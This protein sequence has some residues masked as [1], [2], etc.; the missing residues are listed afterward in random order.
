MLLARAND[1]TN[2]ASENAPNEYRGMNLTLGSSSSTRLSGI[3]NFYCF[4]IKATGGLQELTKRASVFK[5][6]SS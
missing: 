6:A 4:I 2:S 5:E 3:I 1:A